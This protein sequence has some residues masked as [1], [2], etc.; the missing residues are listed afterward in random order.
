M[1]AYVYYTVDD[2]YRDMARRLLNEK[3][4]H[5]TRELRNVMVTISDLANPITNARN[6]SLSY[7]CGELLWYTCSSNDVSFIS[8]F[9]KKWSDITDDGNTS[10]S[11]Y[12]YIIAKKHGFHQLKKVIKLLEKDRYSRRAIINFNVPNNKKIETK[13]EICTIALQ[14]LIRNDKLH[15]TAMMRSNDFYTGMPYDIAFFVSLQ[16]MIAKKLNVEVG[17]YTHFV[18]SLHLYDANVDKLKQA[19]LE[20]QDFIE[21][22]SIAL[23][24]LNLNDYHTIKNSDY[25]RED[26]IKL[27]EKKGIISV[28]RWK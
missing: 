23:N 13:D 7:L 28:T 14:F 27:F 10:N 12:G 4:E 2:M 1:T 15:C 3:S 22:D 26:V 8:R 16:K 6:I 5:G 24:K 11:A 18:T 9:A 21:L 25:P 17:E 20:K 19:L